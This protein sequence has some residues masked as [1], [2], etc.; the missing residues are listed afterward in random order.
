MFRFLQH[1]Y[2]SPLAPFL[3]LL[4]LHLA[5]ATQTFEPSN[6]TSYPSND[7]FLRGIRGRTP[8]E[9]RQ[10]T[11]GGL[12]CPLTNFCCIP[13]YSCCSTTFCCAPGYACYAPNPCVFADV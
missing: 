8:L 10:C 2:P 12:Y 4:T 3:C 13:K 7:V 1:F 6:L 9:K 5:V 11:T